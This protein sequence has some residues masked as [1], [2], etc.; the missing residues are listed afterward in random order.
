MATLADLIENVV[1]IKK[2]ID[3]YAALP[4]LNA[5]QTA[6][7]RTN[8]GQLGKNLAA[9]AAY[10][11]PVPIIVPLAVAPV[12]VAGPAAPNFGESDAMSAGLYGDWMAKW[13]VARF[14]DAYADWPPTVKGIEAGTLAAAAVEDGCL[15]QVTACGN[16]G[17]PESRGA[18]L[19]DFSLYTALTST[20]T[21][22]G[23]WNHQV[24]HMGKL[25]GE[26]IGGPNDGL[27]FAHSLGFN[28]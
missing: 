8:L 6:A 23:E 14:P 9:L 2:H 7:L 26:K 4:R 19:G 3:V 12:K 13:V 22:T 24:W 16:F 18:D 10:E 5:K 21:D 28:W 15:A 20:S 11:A 27:D 25:V 17:N 1:S